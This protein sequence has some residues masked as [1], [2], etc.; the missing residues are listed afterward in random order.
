MQ[1]EA[2]ETKNQV[3]RKKERKETQFLKKAEREACIEKWENEHIQGHRTLKNQ[4][5]GN[6]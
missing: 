5:M 3:Y 2:K 6:S 4:V 1:R